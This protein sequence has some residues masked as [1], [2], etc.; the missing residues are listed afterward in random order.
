MVD[1]VQQCTCTGLQNDM[2]M[3]PISHTQSDVAHL[4]GGESCSLVRVRS[5]RA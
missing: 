1:R 4:K 5:Y 3:I 2:P